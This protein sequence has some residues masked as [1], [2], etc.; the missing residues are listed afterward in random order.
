MREHAFT[1]LPV[2]NKADGITLE[3]Y[4]RLESI[5]CELSGNL[6]PD[7]V[8]KPTKFEAASV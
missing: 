7:M 1:R 5:M 3:G 8:D 2:L 6:A 4:I